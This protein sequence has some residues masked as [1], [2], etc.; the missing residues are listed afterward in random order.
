MSVLHKISVNLSDGQKRKLAKAYRDKEEVSIKLSNKNLS[1]SDTL[2]VPQNIVKRL[3]K[4]KANGKGIQ[5]KIS[6]A[7]VRKQTG[8]GIASSVLP[9]LRNVAPTIGK[10][11][12]LA[13]LAGL[14]SEGASQIIKKIQWWTNL[15]S[16][17][18][19]SLQ[20]SNDG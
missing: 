2:M 3:A 9:L 11:M 18:P 6:R 13:T 8:S 4:S 20:I 16:T 12:G 19:T 1:G 17:K 7:N 10:T 5:I 15:S 14:A